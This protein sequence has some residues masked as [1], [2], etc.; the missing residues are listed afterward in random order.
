MIRNQ[1]IAKTVAEI[2]RLDTAA[3]DIEGRS[4]QQYGFVTAK[5]KREADALQDRAERKVN[6]LIARLRRDGLASEDGLTTDEANH[7]IFE[8]ID[9]LWVIG[10][11]TWA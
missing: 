8:G 3:L 4:E 9:G 10:D 5:A 6:T 11:G 7:P 2:V 1:T